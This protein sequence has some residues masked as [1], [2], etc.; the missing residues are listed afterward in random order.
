MLLILKKYWAQILIV[1]SLGLLSYSGYSYVYQKGY[2][3]AEAKYTKIIN[4][5]NE[6]IGNRIDA[7]EQ[8][9]IAIVDLIISNRAA[10]AKDFNNIRLAIKGKPTSV[11]IDGQC[12][13]SD[14]FINNFNSAV[15]R[16]NNVTKN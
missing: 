1:V 10:T 7:L 9:S 8:N 12:K 3:K 6:K 11:I 13:P 4:D 2:T 16:A 5:Y 15:E 14:D